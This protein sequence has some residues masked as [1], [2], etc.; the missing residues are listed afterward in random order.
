[1]ILALLSKLD[2]K[3]ALTIVCVVLSLALSLL[4]W[5]NSSLKE[6]LLLKDMELQ[7]AILN[8]QELKLSLD[9][10]NQAFKALQV[11][12]T[13]VD[14]KSI[15]EIVLKDSSCEA[16]LRGYKQIFKELGK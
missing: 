1:M 14:A 15:K 16:E 10:Q 2:I 3:T 4:F 6:D 12:K 8:T 11:K 7:Q 13:F 5:K 9:K